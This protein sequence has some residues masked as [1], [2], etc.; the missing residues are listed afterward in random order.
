M[1]RWI[2]GV[3]KAQTALIRAAGGRMI[4]E[5]ESQA[6]KFGEGMQELLGDDVYALGD[7]V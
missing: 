3:L 1:N 2:D 6:Y 7:V 5:R 4:E